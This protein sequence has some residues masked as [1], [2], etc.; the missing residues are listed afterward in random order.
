MVASDGR[1]Q[2]LAKIREFAKATGGKAP[3][4]LAFERNTGIRQSVWRG[5]YW[6][7]WGDAIAEAGFER[8]AAPEK[9]T[10]N[11]LFEKLA[12]ACRHFGKVPSVMEFR[13]YRRTGKDFPSD[14]SI[15]KHF[16]SKATMLQRL[17]Q[18]ANSN[19][20]YADIA[21]MLTDVPCLTESRREGT[22][23]EGSVYLIRSGSHYKIGRSDD[24]ER[25]V[26]EIRVAQPESAS[27]VHSIR[28]DDPAG[29]EAYWHRRFAEKRAPNG[30]WFKLNAG[31]VAAFKRR[32]YQ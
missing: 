1:Q 16:G 8:N 22:I 28:T 9:L 17:A 19:T 12:E 7:R 27:L 25:R 21:A 30:E 23:R 14:S 26:K 5:K 6:A 20:E 32:K 18:W 29:I 31:D 24:L 13:L 2:I 15:A 4:R 3:G 11:F 10:E